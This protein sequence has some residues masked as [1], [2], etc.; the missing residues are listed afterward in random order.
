MGAEAVTVL[1]LRP[2]PPGLP[3]AHTASPAWLAQQQGCRG[4]CLPRLPPSLTHT[5]ASLRWA[6]GRELQCLERGDS[7]NKEALAMGPSKQKAHGTHL[8]A[9]PGPDAYRLRVLSQ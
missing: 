7:E 9:S 5:Q 2:A 4:V 1:P 3:G 6:L 8:G